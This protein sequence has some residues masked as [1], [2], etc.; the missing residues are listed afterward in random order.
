[1][2]SREQNVAESQSSGGYE[3][4][5]F[6]REIRPE[7]EQAESQAA[8]AAQEAPQR[9]VIS[10]ASVDPRTQS[11]SSSRSPPSAHPQNP[12]NPPVPVPNTAS[13]PQSPTTALGLDHFNPA[14]FDFTSPTAWQALGGMWQVTN[15]VMPTTEQL[16]QYVMTAGMS[17]MNPQANVTGQDWNQSG[18]WS[19]D[20]YA[21]QSEPQGGG[22]GTWQSRGDNSFRGRGGHNSYGGGVP[23]EARVVAGEDSSALS[24]PTTHTGNSGGRMQRVGDRWMFVRDSDTA[25]SS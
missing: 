21:Y 9:P 19:N 10:T 20:G 11:H 17:A 24:S 22:Q 8:P 5:E 2:S 12:Q 23:S 7:S 4:D 6:G 1:M 16:M 14:T 13:T 25:V 3:T 15:G 18:G